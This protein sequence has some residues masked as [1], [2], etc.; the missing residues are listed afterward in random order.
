MASIT[1]KA[2]SADEV[3]SLGDAAHEAISSWVVQISET[4]GAG[5]VAITPKG[6]IAGTDIAAAEYATLHYKVASTG[7]VTAGSSAITGEG[8]YIIPADGMHVY[9]DVDITG[10]FSLRLDAVPVRG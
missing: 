6:K 3:V 8:V 5:S 2:I 10:T 9:L 1:D 7:V 4:S